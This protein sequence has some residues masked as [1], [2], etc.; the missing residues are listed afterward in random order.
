MEHRK[1]KLNIIPDALSRVFAEDFNAAEISDEY[2]N[3]P[4]YLDLAQ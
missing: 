4:E 2:F 1:G 3:D